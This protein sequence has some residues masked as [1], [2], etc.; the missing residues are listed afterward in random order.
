MEVKNKGRRERCELGKREQDVEQR[1]S[2]VNRAEQVRGQDRR[3][4][5]RTDGE[6]RQKLKG[7]RCCE[8]QT[9]AKEAALKELAMTIVF[10]VLL[11]FSSCFCSLFHF[12]NIIPLLSL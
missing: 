9:S 10:C 12:Y 11:C 6:E 8:N 5:E 1:G 3:R 2:G 7:I 4:E